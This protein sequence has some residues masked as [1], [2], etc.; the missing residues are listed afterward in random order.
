M[1]TQWL[2]RLGCFAA[3]AVVMVSVSTPSAW[4][5]P[6]SADKGKKKFEPGDAVKKKREMKI[7]KSKGGNMF[8]LEDI[9]IEGKV[10]KPQAFHVINRKELNL[11]WDVRDPR[12]RRSFLT[13]VV[14]AVKKGPF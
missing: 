13:K 12:F 3:A 6:A 7:K 4:A 1:K 11:E 9:E 14:T 2:K 8:V 10:Y 5:K